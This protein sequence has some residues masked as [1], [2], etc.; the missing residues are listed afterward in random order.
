MP[1]LP[2]HMKMVTMVFDTRFVCYY[3]HNS[4]IPHGCVCL[5]AHVDLSISSAASYYLSAVCFLILMPA[6][7]W[8]TRRR[9]LHFHF[10]L[11]Q[12]SFDSALFA[13]VSWITDTIQSE[14]ETMY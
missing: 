14:P 9:S 2:P 6:D 12:S 11:N 5:K 10:S 3:I 4:L 8:W 7:M 1:A 13:S